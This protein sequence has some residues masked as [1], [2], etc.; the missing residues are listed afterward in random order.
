MKWATVLIP[1]ACLTNFIAAF[2][3]KKLIPD[4]T[5]YIQKIGFDQEFTR[6]YRN[7]RDRRFLACGDGVIDG[8][9]L[10]DDTNILGGDGCAANCMTVETGYECLVAGLPC[11][12]ICGDALDLGTYQCDDGNPFPNDGCSDQCVLEPRG[13]TCTAKPFPT[14]CTEI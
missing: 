12:E 7:L 11:T 4:T 8:T 14:V 13:F 6:V 9:E 1:L 3:G 5:L 10:C 2:I